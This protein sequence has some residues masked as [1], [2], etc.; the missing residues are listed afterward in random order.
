MST[1][2]TAAMILA[3]VGDPEGV[4]A[5]QITAFWNAYATVTRANYLVFLYTKRDAIQ[6]LQ[7]SVR[8][9]VT[10]QEDDL[11]IVASDYFKNL[12][13]MYADVQAEIARW[14][15]ILRASSGIAVG[16]LTATTSDPNPSGDPN[17]I[18][19]ESAIVRGDAYG[20]MLTPSG[21]PR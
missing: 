8:T 13:A 4:L 2:F 9:R 14:E 18:A 7:G 6:I 5:P 12:D 19:A 3:Q 15:K 1:S 21:L 10:R 20:D 16:V 17:S 11:K